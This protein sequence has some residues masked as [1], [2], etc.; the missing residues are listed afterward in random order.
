MGTELPEP[1]LPAAAGA[2][3]P[4]AQETLP[5]A[6]QE[7]EGKFFLPPQSGQYFLLAE[8]SRKP[9]ARDSGKCSL[10]LSCPPQ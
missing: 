4:A 9:A 3:A 2:N 10:Q 6:S 1:A 7:T 8:P 5:G